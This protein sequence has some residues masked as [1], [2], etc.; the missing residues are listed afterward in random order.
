MQS[1]RR[2]L[3]TVFLLVTFLATLLGTGAAHALPPAPDNLA[4]SNI[5]VGSNPIFSWDAVNFASSYRIQISAEADFSPLLYN[6]TTANT[7]YTPIA[8]LPTGTIHWRVAATDVTGTGN[9]AETEFTKSLGGPTLLAP[10]DEHDFD[11]PQ[12]S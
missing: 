9:Y 5:D 10:D 3:V 12:E 6:A 4:P 7:Q 8:E 11:F 2:R 1:P